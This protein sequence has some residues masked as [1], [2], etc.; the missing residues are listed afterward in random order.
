MSKM[1]RIYLAINKLTSKLIRRIIAHD[2]MSMMGSDEE[3]E[4][5]GALIYRESPS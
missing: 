5:Y 3:E 2:G 4:D 1:P